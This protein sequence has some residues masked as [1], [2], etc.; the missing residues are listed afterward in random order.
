MEFAFV[1][2]FEHD[3]GVL[4]SYDQPCRLPLQYVGRSGRRVTARHTPDYFVLRTDTAG[5]EECKTDQELF[6]LAEKSPHRYKR[7]GDGTWHCPLS[8]R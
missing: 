8:T 7:E 6:K 1:L 4:E 5:W 2:E 3:A